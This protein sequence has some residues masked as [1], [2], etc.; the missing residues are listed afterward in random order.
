M[1]WS[2]TRTSE[3]VDIYRLTLS[4]DYS[5]VCIDSHTTRVLSL[6]PDI[7]EELGGWG[8]SPKSTYIKKLL[9]FSVFS[10][11]NDFI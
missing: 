6:S 5:I 1:T 4:F 3:K 11:S 7:I 8:Y 10:L 9:H 2:H